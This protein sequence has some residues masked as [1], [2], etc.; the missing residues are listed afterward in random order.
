M[1]CAR[2]GWAGPRRSSCSTWPRGPWRC[3]WRRRC[4]RRRPGRRMGGR[5]GGRGGRGRAQLVGLHRLRGGRG[6]ATGRRGVLVISPLDVAAAP[7]EPSSSCSRATCRWARWWRPLTAPAV[8]AVLPRGVG[9][10]A[11]D[12]VVT[13]ALPGHR[14]R[15]PTT[16]AGCGTAPSAGSAR[17]QRARMAERRAPR[18]RCGPAAAEPRLGRSAR[19]AAATPVRHGAAAATRRGYADLA[20]AVVF[21]GGRPDRHRRWEDRARARRG[22]PLGIFLDLTADKVLVAGVLI[23]MVEVR[24]CRPGSPRCCS[25]ASWWCRAFGS[26]RPRGRGHAGARPGQGQD[27]RHAARAWGCCCS[28]TTPPPADR[29]PSAGPGDWLTNLGRGDHARWRPSLSVVSGLR[30][31]RAACRSCWDGSPRPPT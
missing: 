30:Y 22:D 19:I 9:W 5:G 10:A 25:S 24:C 3:C 15:T 11:V 7:V 18:H 28:R 17:R 23:A 14:S 29:W 6:V 21:V 2:L 20:A 12:A 27:L 1:R 16:C 31:V 8:T 13:A 26:W 4:T